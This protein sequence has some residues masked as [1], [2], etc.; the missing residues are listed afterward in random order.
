MA[1]DSSETWA[2]FLDALTSVGVEAAKKALGESDQ[3]VV[4]PLPPQAVTPTRETLLWYQR[5]EIVIPGAIGLAILGW[6][7]FFKR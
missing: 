2:G 6:L 3:K 7:A 4:P 1:A 5:M